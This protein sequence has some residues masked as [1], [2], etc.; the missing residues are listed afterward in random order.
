VPCG[1]MRRE[2]FLFA[3][4]RHVPDGAGTVVG[5]EE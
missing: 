3:C 2:L 5:D 1:L 4:I